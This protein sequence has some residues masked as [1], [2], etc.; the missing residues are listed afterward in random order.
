VARLA[1]V[2]P[3]TVSRVL[4]GKDA[5]HISEETRLHVLRALKELDYVPTKAARTLRR[6]KSGIIAVLIPDITNPFFASL[7]HGVESEGFLKGLSVMICDSNHSHEKEDRY[8]DILLK[9]GVDGIVFVP[10]DIPDVKKLERLVRHGVNVV[11]ADRRVEGWPVV[12]ADNR[13]GS[14]SLTKYV[15]SLGYRRV[16]YIAGPSNVSTS[17]DRV[18]GFM[19]AVKEAGLT[20]IAV[21]H[22]DFTFESG[23]R[24]AQ[25]LLSER[26][27]ELILCGNDLMAIGALRAAAELQI[28]VPLELGIT[29]FDHI[30]FA[31]LVHPPLTTV[32]VPAFAIGAEAV[33]LLLSSGRT[34][35][36]LETKIIFGGTCV[37]RG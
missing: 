28:K 26:D 12:E 33:G 21:E 6:Q 14:Y 37:P 31:D 36:R 13:G 9:E 19:D 7:A 3:T 5:N 4:N 1:G 34:S 30:Q 32:E 17:L 23:Y 18:Q 15:I 27:V 22:G 2:S 20:P 8:L 11:V 24:V 16:A 35:I 25:R 10:V 29:G